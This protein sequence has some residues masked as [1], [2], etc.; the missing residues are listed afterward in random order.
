MLLWRKIFAMPSR[1]APERF[2]TTVL[3][4]DIVG[5]T[6][7]SAELGDSAWRDLVRMHNELVRASLRRNGGREID[8]AGDGF[9][10]VFDAPAAAVKSA[11]ELSRAVAGLGIE[12][13]AGVHVGEVE[14]AGRKVTGITVPIASRI[15]A[16]A[17]ASEV[18]VTA[19]VRDL[20]AGAGL[21]FDDRGNHELKGVPGMWQVFEVRSASAEA[22]MADMPDLADSPG[23]RESAVRRARSRPVWQRNPRAAGVAVGVVALAVVGAGLWMWKPW[24][25]PALSGIEEDSLGV[26]DGGRSEIVA[27]IPVGAHPGMMAAAD[28][29]VWVTN[30]AADT[31][32][33]VDVSTRAVTREIDVGRTPTGIAIGGGSVWVANSGERTVS[34][35]NEETARVVDTITVGNSPSAVAAGVGAI[36]VANSADSSVVR[37]DQESGAVGQPITVAAVPIALA[38][39]ESGVWVA[40]SDGA[41]VT[42]LDRGS[43]RSVAAP[44]ALSSRPVALAIGHGSIWVANADGTV[45]RIDASDNRVTA[46]IDLGVVPSAIST[47]PSAVWVAD[48]AGYLYRLDP[49]NTMQSPLRIA[50]GSAPQTLAT[51]GS[52]LWVGT[53]PGLDSHRGGTLRI[54]TVVPSGLDP[55]DIASI[56]NATTLEADGLVGYR[57]VGGNAGSTLLPDLAVALPRP[58]NGGLSYTFQLRPDLHY[59]TGV[60][61]QPADFRRAIERSFQVPS[62]PFGALGSIFFG[63]VVGADGCTQPDLAP[64]QRCDLSAGITVDDGARTITFNLAQPDPDFLYKLASTA[65][66]PVPEGVPMNAMVDA[67]FPGTGPYTVTSVSDVELRLSRNPNFQLWDRDVRPDGFPDEIVWSYGLTAD[68][69]I[70]LVENGEADFL[71][72]RGPNRLSPEQLASLGVQ[73]PAQLHF[74]SIVTEG[75]V[76]DTTVPPFDRLEARQALSLAIDREHVAALYGGSP[77][78]AITCQFLQAGTPGYVPYCPYTAAAD[79]GGQ[80]H[81]RDVDAA[82]RLV[83]Q[84]GTSGVSVVVGPISRQD[85]V[86]QRDYYAQVVAEL[87][88]DVT[89]DEAI[90][91]EA[92]A[93]ASREGR[94]QLHLSGWI[95]DY[96][97]PGNF[98]GWL[99]CGSGGA[100]GF[101]DPDFDALYHEALDVQMID[102]AA[103]IAN[104]TAVDHAAVDRAIWI[105]LVLSGS[106]FLSERVGN[107]QFNPAYVFLF[108]QLWVQ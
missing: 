41:V 12:I 27:S 106:D 73:Y 59:S 30:P 29:S 82:R 43:G 9:F 55:L 38:A 66:Y 36:W 103:A 96:F 22:S 10:A 72:G 51:V 39:D 65:A 53:V 32:S 98:F 63:S 21:R 88:Y 60:A 37:I 101:C 78:V 8:T 19:T 5:S 23:R 25:P 80:W 47:S 35:I 97:A 104:W 85:L 94:L 75:L 4:T 14:Q 81:G 86:A 31:V 52:D 71:I 62:P 28:G 54:V 33:R 100:P 61:V 93:T 17:G 105:P 74:G 69:R 44:V 76:I 91:L 13:R 79:P 89:V 68:E 70:A 16:L 49:S 64:V 46:T 18:L 58:A 95:P 26:V 92:V 15:M 7:H 3:M 83:E 42:R 40:S 24:Q 50:T 84:S 1:S 34:R 77:G 48:K 107:Y 87:G 102:P 90:G 57:R 99:T 56:G 2:L 20:A 45:T 67:A 108:D 11:L 6:Q